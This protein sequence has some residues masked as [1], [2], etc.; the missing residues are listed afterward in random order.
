MKELQEY[1][2]KYLYDIEEVQYAPEDADYAVFDKLLLSE[3]AF[4]QANAADFWKFYITP[5]AIAWN[6]IEKTMDNCYENDRFILYQ[7]K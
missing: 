1:L 2:M 6:N 3:E 7:K 4:Q 5:E